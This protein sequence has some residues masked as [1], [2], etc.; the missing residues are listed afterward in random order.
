MWPRLKC[1]K[2]LHGIT[3]RTRSDAQRRRRRT[4]FSKAQLAE[5]EKAFSITHYPDI[6]MKESLASRTGLP[7]STIQV[8]FQ[9]R[10]ARYFKSKKSSREL[11]KPSVEYLYPPSPSPPYSNFGASFPFTA[12][13]PPVY[14]A[15][16]LPQSTRLSAL[17]ESPS[18]GIS[19]PTSHIPNQT[20]PSQDLSG[21]FQN[22]FSEI[23]DLTDF[24]L[25][26]SPDMNEWELTEDFEAFLQDSQEVEPEGSRCAAVAHHGFNKT[27]E[28]LLEK[29]FS[30][31]EGPMDDLSDIC[32][33]DLGEFSLSDLNISAAMID[34]LL[35]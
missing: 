10:R 21:A 33:Q 29:H 5:L 32:F 20:T 34:Y 19:A 23:L 25:D 14:P 2:C 30:T 35:G 24:P 6:K 4:T 3:H 12:P 17:L 28:S 22:H 7:E 18:K 26:A 13:S 31:T 15:P 1:Q 16:C 8:W 27:V 9:N 11:P